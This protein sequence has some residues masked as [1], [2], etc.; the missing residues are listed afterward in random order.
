MKI[1]I[2]V[3]VYNRFEYVENIIKCLMNQ[4]IQPYEVIFTNDGSKDDLKKILT[5]Y[6]N[7]C[8]F[9]IKHIY[10]ED[11]GFRKSKV[12]NNAVI[13]SEGDY[14]IFL[15]Q[16][17]IFPNDLIEMFINNKKENKFSILRVIWSENFERIEIQKILNKNKWKYEEVVS[18]ISNSHFKV[19]KRH[20]WRDKYNNF[21]YKIGLRDRG[22]GLMGI[23]FALFKRDYLEINGY[24]EDYKGWGGEDADLGLRLYAFGLSS[25][26]FSTK[27]P[28]LHMCHPLDPTKSGSLNKK[29]YSEKKEKINKKNYKCTFGMNNRKD[30]DGYYLEKI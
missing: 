22:T 28:S 8:K 26:A 21:R 7:E 5:K 25:I 30:L 20:L 13:E 27:I 18:K 12:C 14:L 10:Q 15:D 24:D 23:G 19:L 3:T 11:L 9:K 1:S 29:M 4:R 6:K 16:D 17:V 2:I